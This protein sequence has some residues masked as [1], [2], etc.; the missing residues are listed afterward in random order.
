MINVVVDVDD[1]DESDGKKN[2]YGL[3]IERLD[4]EPYPP[5]LGAV[6]VTVHEMK[7][8]SGQNYGIRDLQHFENRQFFV[9]SHFESSWRRPFR[10]RDLNQT[11]TDWSLSDG[12]K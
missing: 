3:V 11:L 5:I 8:K 2:L 4:T 9:E 7:R 6:L 12:C 10:F 1:D